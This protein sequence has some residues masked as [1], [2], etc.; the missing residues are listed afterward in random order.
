MKEQ[1]QLP[2][3]KE[4]KRIVNGLRDLRDKIAHSN[5][6]GIDMSWEDIIDLIKICENLL[7]RSEIKARGD[8][9]SL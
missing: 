7:Q 6:L 4:W 8:S 3:N 5:E 9:A 1:L 2:G